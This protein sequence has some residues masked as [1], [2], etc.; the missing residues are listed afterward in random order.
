MICDHSSPVMNALRDEAF[1][2]FKQQG[3]PSKKVERYKYTDI[4]KL[5]AP[6]YGLNLNRLPIPVD[7]Y[8]AF[9]C[10]VPNLSTLL[11]FIVNDDFYR[12]ERKDD[13]GE[14]QLMAATPKLP[15]GVV[16]GSLKEHAEL[17]KA[18][19]GTVA[20][21]EEDSLTALNTMLA[22]DGLLVYVPK[23]TVIDKTVQVI[24]ILKA[25]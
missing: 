10:D 3:F 9:K 15:E 20:R 13:K 21:S 2:H 7:P 23:N 25:P 18:Y 5:M 14:K 17:A 8:E 19:Y 16:I 4:E 12:G 1:E 22:Q 24:N 6:D 11:Y